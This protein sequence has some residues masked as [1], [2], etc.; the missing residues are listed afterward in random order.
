MSIETDLNGNG[1]IDI[2]FGGTNAVDAP[3]ARFNLGLGNVD[4]TS[5][6]D[7][8]ISNLTQ[9][10]LNKKVTGP[11][12]ATDSAVVQYDGATGELIKDGPLIGTSPNNIPQLDGGGKLSS[13]LS[14][15]NQGGTG[16]T[17]RT[18]EEKLQEHV[19]VSDFGAVADGSDET[20]KIQAAIDSLDSIVGGT[21]WLSQGTYRIQSLN[22]KNNVTIKGISFGSVTLKMVD[23]VD[24][25]LFKNPNA[26]VPTTVDYFG[27]ENLILD[28]NQAYSAGVTA[29]SVVDISG[30][31]FFRARDV[32]FKNG[33]G[34]GLGLQARIGIPQSGVQ[35]E[36][37]LEN[38]YYFDNG[39][40]VGGDT[41]DG[42]DIKD[43]D[44]IT[45]IGGGASGNSDKGIDIRGEAV[46]VS[47]VFSDNNGSVGFGFSGNADGQSLASTI[48]VSDVIARNNVTGFAVSDGHGTP[49]QTV[50]VNLSNYIAHGNTYGIR[51]NTDTDKVD[52]AA[53]GLNIFSNTSH[54]I[55]LDNSTQLK[56]VL[57]DFIINNN[58][59]SGI[60]NNGTKLL[61]GNGSLEDNTR[62]GY[63]EGVGA[64]RN[65]LTSP[66]YVRDNVIGEWLFNTKNYHMDEGVSDFTLNSSSNGD[67][68]ASAAT[69]TLPEGGGVFFITGTVNIT[70]V[71]AG[72]RGRSIKLVFSGVL[73]FV[74]GSNLN[75][76]ADLVTASQ[77][78]ITLV[79][80][81]MDWF[82]LSRSVN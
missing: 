40:G 48:N 30:L 79:G 13:S 19:S 34:Y 10:E 58:G 5:D 80:D 47:G 65:S 76:S 68:I 11:A 73:T 14:K 23:G 45:L 55:S 70:S 46:S 15:Y 39:V 64:T 3:D 82:E 33:L 41:F 7:K 81:G 38:C 61:L 71:T 42:L 6:A 27:L 60:F 12:T 51:L 25:Q 26:S 43:C 69:I 37:Y 29:T 57:S 59:G 53:S 66:L 8:P 21:V 52:F 63:E 75:L 16:A 35:T 32:I 28:G 22:A 36:I 31:T 67:I 44:K 50:R 62:Y 18:V 72:R 56:I 1:A 49:L 78:T 74:N 4:N 54:G 77:T 20:S 2:E 9:T 24:K 17:D